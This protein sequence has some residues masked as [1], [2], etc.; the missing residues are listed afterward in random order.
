MAIDRPLGP[1]VVDLVGVELAAGE[2]E[3]LAHPL[4][5]GVI[6]F[7]RNYAAPD[8]LRALTRS[9]HAVR[10]PPLLVAVDHEGGRVQRSEEHTSELQSRLHLLCRLLLLKIN[11][12]FSPRQ[13]STSKHPTLLKSH[14]IPIT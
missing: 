6:L 13:Y 3:I 4:V 5:G 12:T 8:Q 7:A 11:I 10:S 9:I 14:F 2:G 1:V